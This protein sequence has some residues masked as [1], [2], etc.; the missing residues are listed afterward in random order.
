MK[1]NRPKDDCLSE[2]LRERVLHLGAALLYLAAAHFQKDE[3]AKFFQVT[4]ELM[5]GSP[6]SVYPLGSPP[7]R[8]NSFCPRPQLTVGV[9]AQLELES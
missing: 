1:K 4:T 5:A 7:T 6:G 3:R 2:E 9:V 8:Y